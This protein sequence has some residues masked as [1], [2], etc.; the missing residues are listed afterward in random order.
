MARSRDSPF[1]KNVVYN[2]Y[3]VYVII[4]LSLPRAE[5]RFCSLWSLNFS[6]PARPDPTRPAIS[7]TR[8]P[9]LKTVDFGPPILALVGPFWGRSVALSIDEFHVEQSLG[10]TIHR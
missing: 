5:R 3:Y 6:H 9:A 7:A 4:M 8:L 2:Y 1:R 10:R